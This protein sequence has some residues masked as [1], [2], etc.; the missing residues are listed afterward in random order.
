MQHARVGGFVVLVYELDLRLHS[1]DLYFGTSA[2]HVG[3][4]SIA[5]TRIVVRE[6]SIGSQPDAWQLDLLSTFSVSLAA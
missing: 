6:L 5:S 2:T 3:M 4:Y 1:T